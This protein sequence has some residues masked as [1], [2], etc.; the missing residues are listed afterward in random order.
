MQGR[1]GGLLRILDVSGAPPPSG[2]WGGGGDQ[3]LRT[4]GL[5]RIWD[6]SGEVV[7]CKVG[8]VVY[9]GFR[10]CLG[11]PPCGVSCTFPKVVGGCGLASF[12][13]LWGGGGLAFF[14]RLWGVG[15]ALHYS[16]ACGG[17]CALALSQGLWDG[18]LRIR[19]LSGEVVGTKLP[20]RGGLLRI[21]DVSGAPPHL[22]SGEVVGPKV[23]G[24]RVY[25]GFGMCLGRWWRARSPG[26]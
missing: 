7:A 14:Q 20:G 18:L 3:G 11:R 9:L 13:R 24:P 25:L 22:V 17:R 16:Q 6:V 19:D 5:L 10:M 8:G 2:V 12:Q 26:P 15:F 1:R 4:H 21:L 23:C